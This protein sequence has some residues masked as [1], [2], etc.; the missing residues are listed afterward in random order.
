MRQLPPPEAPAPLAAT[1]IGVTITG[2]ERAALVAAGGPPR[3]LRIGQELDGWRVL[4][5]EPDRVHMRRGDE[6]ALLRL[7]R[8]R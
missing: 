8:E 5:I 1:L 3:W 2:E 7:R 4:S 6:E